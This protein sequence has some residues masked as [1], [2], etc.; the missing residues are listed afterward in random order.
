M[1]LVLLLRAVEEA[2]IEM[3]R[4]GAGREAEVGVARFVA[5]EAT[6]RAALAK[7][8]VWSCVCDVEVVIL[9]MLARETTEL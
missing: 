5:A 2:C 8:F 6:P 9:L 3:E 1:T 4:C 7:P